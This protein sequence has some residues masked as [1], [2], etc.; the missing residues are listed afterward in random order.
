M[1]YDVGLLVESYKAIMIK[2]LERRFYLSNTIYHY[3]SLNLSINL[4]LIYRCINAD[5]NYGT[6]WFYCRPLPFDNPSLVLATAL[7]TLGIYLSIN[8][9]INLSI[10]KSIYL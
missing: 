6:S 10:Y 4:S 5:P 2:K 8:L 7:N 9:S 3:L 1:D